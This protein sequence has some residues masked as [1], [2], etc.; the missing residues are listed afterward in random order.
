MPYTIQKYAH[1][2]YQYQLNKIESAIKQGLA[3]K[4]IPNARFQEIKF[5]ASNIW[6]NAI[7]ALVDM[8]NLDKI[9][10]DRFDLMFTSMSHIES[11]IKKMEASGEK[12]Y[13]QIL[14]NDFLPFAKD[15]LTLKSY[16]VKKSEMP[17]IEK[18]L[19][20]IPKPPIGKTFKPERIKEITEIVL[21]ACQPLI[22][23]AV[24]REKENTQKNVRHYFEWLK[25]NTKKTYNDD[26]I[27][28]KQWHIINHFRPYD[29]KKQFM[30]KSFISLYFTRIV[31][32][33]RNDN[34]KKDF[35]Y[36]VKFEPKS[37]KKYFQVYK[38]EFIIWS[39][40]K[41]KKAIL[42]ALYTDDFVD[43]KNIKLSKGVKGFEINAILINDEGKNFNFITNAISAG[44]YN[45]Q[46]FH[47]R[48]LIK[49]KL[50]K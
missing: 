19:I 39:T 44:G 49:I 2:R 30:E 25:E 24:K 33:N 23:E 43:I 3:E 5:T 10:F 27:K 28:N 31:N 20:K 35:K 8:T 11:K 41:L 14:R 26:N 48:Y 9:G 17:K 47:Y 50:I 13:S 22:D 34:W 7:N 36:N 32:D 40:N 1:E 18:P 45:I 21:K 46:C 38:E 4:F 12:K 37:Y 6:E 15:I 16:A 29:Y 42:T